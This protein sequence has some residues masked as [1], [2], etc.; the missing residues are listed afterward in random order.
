MKN[1]NI[2]NKKMSLA[3]DYIPVRELLENKDSF[4]T[5]KLRDDLG[6]PQ[7]AFVVG[8]SGTIEWRKGID[9]FPQIASRALQKSSIPMYFLW[10]GGDRNNAEF[11]KVMQDLQKVKLHKEVL[12]VDYKIDYFSMIDAFILPSREDPYPLVCLQAAAFEKPVI[13]FEK[14]GGMPEFVGEECGFVVPYLNVE[15][16]AEKIAYLAENRYA[17]SELGKNAA[18]KVLDRHDV[19][20]ISRE[21]LKIINEISS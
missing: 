14:A 16:A 18:E 10:I 11:G 1:H 20:K 5:D 13:C 4:D 6:I 8:A 21:L 9:L 17:A 3:Y 15:K 19:E 7:D 12:F 2:P